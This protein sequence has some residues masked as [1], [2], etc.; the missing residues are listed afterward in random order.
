MSFFMAPGT[1]LYAGSTGDATHHRR[2]D[3]DGF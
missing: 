1:L 2:E 3:I